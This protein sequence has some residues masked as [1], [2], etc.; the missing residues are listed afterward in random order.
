MIEKGK[1]VCN[2]CYW[3]GQEEELLKAP[4]PFDKDEIL[5]GCPICFGVDC[6]E[7]ICDEKG[8]TLRRSCGTPSEEGYRHTCYKHKPKK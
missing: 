1:V 8:C 3:Q 7:Y 6:F 4:N 5:L 2:K